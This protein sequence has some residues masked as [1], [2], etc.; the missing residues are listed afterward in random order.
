M[1]V[2]AKAEGDQDM[3]RKEEA[4]NKKDKPQVIFE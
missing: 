3:Q 4:F 1:N 2:C